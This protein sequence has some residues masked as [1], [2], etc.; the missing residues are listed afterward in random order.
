MPR[1]I[2]KSREDDPWFTQE[3]KRCLNKKKRSYKK[4]S[5][6]NSPYDWQNYKS[7]SVLAEKTIHDAKH[8]YFNFTLPNMLKNDP[9]RFWKVV[10][11][12]NNHSVPTLQGDDGSALP[13]AECAKVFNNNFAAVFTDEL[14]LDSS[15]TLVPPHIA[16]PFAPI[17][18]TAHGVQCAIERLPLKTSPGPDGISA[19]LLKLTKH[20]S[21][22]ILSLIFQQSIDT[23]C[24]PDDW[25]SA[26]I[27]PI[28]KSGDSSLPGN[29]RPIS[30]T[31]ISC[32]LLEHII[33]KHIMIY[34]ND[35]N[36]LHINQH[37]FR[38]N[39]SCQSQLFELVTDLHQSLHSS[40]YVDAILV[41]FSKAF[42]RVPHNRLIL[43]LRNLQLDHKTT[44]WIEQFLTNRKQFVKIQNHISTSERVI[45]GVP[46]GSVLGPLLFLIYINDISTDINASIRLF[47]D[48]CIIYK[49]IR[50]PTDTIDLQSALS[51]LTDWCSLW[52]MQINTDKTKHLK[53]SMTTNSQTSSYTID[54]IKI[55]TVLTYKYLGVIFNST[56]TW[57]DHIEYITS[58]ALKKLGLLK[59][60]LHLANHDTRLLA[61]NSL[62][63]PSLEYASIIWHPHHVTWTNHL[64]AVQNKA[65]RFILSSYSRLQSVTKLKSTL[66][67]HSLA[68]RRTLARLSFFHSLYHSGSPFSRSHIYPAHHISSRLDHAYKVKPIFSRTDKYRN[69]PLALS[70]DQWN[71]LPSSI[72][73]IN[74]HQSFQLALHSFL[75]RDT[76][77]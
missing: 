27:I 14:P 20:H 39:L 49:E 11:P 44:K 2:I 76:T 30:L 10:N 42:D 61:Y 8:E 4:A 41:D 23:G 18:V 46:Q 13:V 56:L 75:E 26:F 71:S 57:N 72:A 22:Y 77:F 19:K 48:D 15:L 68:L 25:R 36:L 21:A 17:T 43:K 67:M 69:S 58:K 53:F 62:I 7:I 12:K 51:K 55:D 59:R 31:S 29:Y 47:A 50:T 73:T 1:R 5:Q 38:K 6:T 63:R 40:L 65:A 3:V 28:F 33:H 52:Q 35:N 74:D 70:I 34:L 60:R 64:E 37:G 32:K 54:N 16:L 45:S 24:V 9:Q 66:D